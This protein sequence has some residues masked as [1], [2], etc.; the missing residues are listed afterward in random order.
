M[1]LFLVTLFC[2][3]IKIN[4]AD[5]AV[6]PVRCGPMPR[7]I[8]SCLSMPK[9]VKPEISEQCKNRGATQCDRMTCIF[10]QSGW[11]VDNK[12]QEVKI[13]SFFDD[14]AKQHPSWSA[15]VNHV[16]SAC[17]GSSLPAQG[18]HLN[19]PAYDVMQCSLASFIKNGL[20][21]EW[22]TA[23]HCEYP[24]HF[25]ASCPVCPG[26]CFEPQIPTGSCNACLALP[27]SP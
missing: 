3:G 21:S 25:A 2:V 5:I 11:I 18:I 1:F 22:S 26:D 7:A 27:R 8:F 14:F 6:S 10:E 20:P 9:I 17:L 13:R 4:H 12:L 19:C 15:A 24:R 23:S 16:K